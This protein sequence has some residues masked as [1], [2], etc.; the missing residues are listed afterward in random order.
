MKCIG[1][2]W[3]KFFRAW[4]LPFSFWGSRAWIRIPLLFGLWHAATSV[5]QPLLFNQAADGVTIEQGVSL[6]VEGGVQTGGG[7]ADGWFNVEGSI[8]V[9][10][11]CPADSGTADW[12]VNNLTHGGTEGDGWVQLVSGQQEIGGT[13]YPQFSNLL[14]GATSEF[15]G[16][17][18]DIRVW[19][20]LDL[21]LSN[22]LALS[23]NELSLM[24]NSPDALD[25]Q[26]GGWLVS[27]SSPDGGVDYG[28]VYWETESSSDS[29]WYRIPFGT[30]VPNL[31]ID[32]LPMLESDSYVR[33]AT[34]GTGSDNLPLPLTGRG[35]SGDVGD[36][37]G[38]VT[39]GDNTP[40][41]ID[42]F[43]VLD[44]GA[45][46]RTM[47]LRFL[48]A[49]SS[50]GVV[51][52]EE[53]LQAQHWGAGGWGYPGVGDPEWPGMPS[54]L[55]TISGAG[56]WTLATNANP[57][58]VGCVEFKAEPLSGQVKLHWTTQTEL[59]NKGFYIERT[60]DSFT[61]ESIGF[62]KGTGT[63][64]V[65]KMYVFE[66]LSPPLNGSY[67]RLIQQ[68]ENGWTEQACGVLNAIP[69]PGSDD[70]GGNLMLWPNPATDQILGSWNGA[71]P[72]QVIWRLLTLEGREIKREE[73]LRFEQGFNNKLSQMELNQGE[74]SMAELSKGE[75]S[76]AEINLAEISLADLS[77][78]C[79][80]LFRL[81]PFLDPGYRMLEIRTLIGAQTFTEH[82]LILI[83]P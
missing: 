20:T 83:Q 7:A 4:L 68:D 32:F 27:E 81:P 50:G 69:L 23:G 41:T 3:R 24:L 76:R 19:D 66:D 56:A 1:I 14:L 15:Y 35:L 65:P 52:L 18:S 31:A 44:P 43:W 33:A 57:L 75:L 34:Y 40:W 58:P 30:I 59:N 5:G 73:L 39:G 55:A 79:S 54:V 28:T 2:Y 16:L 36:L 47:R 21:G 77:Q 17:A 49:E 53:T 82:Q 78:T 11:N 29:T 46:A 37:Y 6:F 71:M 74:L 61:W 48:P 42:R 12:T 25:W 62:V 64:S 80:V 72:E 45:T 9:G 63:S 22:Q 51:G 10:Q 38:M 13:G 60:T 67:Y 70:S 26:N 8:V